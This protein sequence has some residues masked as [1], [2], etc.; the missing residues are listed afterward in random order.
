MVRWVLLVSAC[1]VACG[2]KAP[3]P[4][5]APPAPAPRPIDAA[6]ASIDA[7][8]PPPAPAAP[9]SKILQAVMHAG[10]TCARR[11]DGRVRCWGGGAAVPVEVSGITTAIAIDISDG[12][13]IYIVTADGHVVRSTGEPF[14]TLPDA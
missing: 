10:K 3:A 6:T 4:H 12:G 14:E 1:A 13:E 9:A 5:D 8:G 2:K 11:A 7:A